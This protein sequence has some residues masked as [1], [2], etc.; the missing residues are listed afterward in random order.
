MKKLKGVFINAEQ[1]TLTEIESTF[2]E[3]VEKYL[4]DMPAIAHYIEHEEGHIDVVYGCDN[5]ITS[6][7][8]YGF[9]IDES[10]QDFFYG[11]GIVFGQC[12]KTGESINSKITV[13]GMS[14]H[15]NGFI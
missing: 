6:G 10:E 7:K 12:L 9:F 1:K 11:N 3:A 2:D 4:K 13:I 15:I 14:K 8:P 5:G